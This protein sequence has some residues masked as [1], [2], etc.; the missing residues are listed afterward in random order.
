MS[1]LFICLP[2]YCTFLHIWYYILKLK[3]DYRYNEDVRQNLN[4]LF[5]MEKALFKGLNIFIS[6]NKSLRR[7]I[8]KNVCECLH[9]STYNFWSKYSK[10]L[11]GNDYGKRVYL[12]ILTVMHT[13]DCCLVF[14]CWPNARKGLL[15][16]GGKENF[17]SKDIKNNGFVKNEKQVN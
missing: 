17:H 7:G 11:H 2:N 1:I 12:S 10:S 5:Q 6:R 14:M 13:N 3:T 4:R 16:Q 8:L 15:I 9:E